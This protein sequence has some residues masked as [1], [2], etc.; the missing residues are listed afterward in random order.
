MAVER[1]IGKHTY[2]VERMSAVDTVGLGRRVGNVIGPGLPMIYRALVAPKE[3]RDDLALVALGAVATQADARFEAMITELAETVQ[4]KWNGEWMAVVAGQDEM[5]Q[6][7]VHLM[8]IAFFAL[9]VNLKSF[10]SAL[11]ARF[12]PAATSASHPAS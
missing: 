12:R 1:K 2:R 7:P 5:V 8:L 10:F 6:D 11:M 9:E 3:S 4:I